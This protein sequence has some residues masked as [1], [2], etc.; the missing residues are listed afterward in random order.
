MKMMH[1]MGKDF[2]DLDDIYGAAERLTQAGIRPSF[3]LIFGDPVR[4]P[5]TLP[6]LASANLAASAPVA[7]DAAHRSTPRLR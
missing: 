2:Q 3:N 1:L 4:Q 5:P 6:R 7:T